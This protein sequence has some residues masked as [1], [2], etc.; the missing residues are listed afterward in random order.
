MSL[1]KF[2]ANQNTDQVCV[3]GSY[4]VC[5]SDARLTAIHIIHTFNVPFAD[6]TVELVC[7]CGILRESKCRERVSTKKRHEHSITFLDQ[8]TISRARDTCNIPLTY[9]TIKVEC[10]I[11][12]C[13]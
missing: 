6:V 2:S 1:L 10:M 5:C 9:V 13:K 12:Y 7:H 4:T 11:K 8:L 3:S